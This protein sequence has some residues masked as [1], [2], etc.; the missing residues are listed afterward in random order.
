[1][2]TSAARFPKPSEIK[3]PPGAEGWETL[4]TYGLVFSEDR[5]A[6][7][8]QAFWFQD[9][10]HWREVLY[11]FD[12]TLAEFAITSLSQYNSR[13]FII[14]PAMGIDYRVVNGYFYLTPVPVA[15]GAT[16]A[17]R[18]PHF[19]ERAG[20]Y[21]QNWG[22]LYDQWKVKAREMIAEME[23]ISFEPLPEMVD[24]EWVT[25]GRGVGSGFDMLAAYNRLIELVFKGWQYHFELLNLGYAAYL[26]FFTFCK[27]VF[28]DIPE[29]SIA[30]MVAG[31]NVELFRPDDELKGLARRA[32]ELGVAE[33]LK[34]AGNAA[35]A[36]ELLRE[37]E[38]GRAWLAALEEAKHPW[39]N[40]S[41]GTGFYHHD[42]V[43]LDDLDIPFGHIVDYIGQ[44]ERGVSLERPLD[45][46]C[47]ERDRVAAEYAALLATD[48]DRET[49]DGKLGLA[50]TVFP[51][52][53]NHNFYIEHWMHSVFW[54]KM[55][56]LGQVFADAGFWAA[57]DDVFYLRRDEIPVAIF[58]LGT[59]W[60]VGAPSR[61][62]HVWPREIE[63]RKR[64][65]KA[66]RAWTPPPALGVPPEVVTEPFTVMLW[67]ITSD[68]IRVWLSGASEASLSGFAASP[69]VVEGVARVVKSSK[70]IDDV[71]AGEVIVC[72][73]TAPG[74]APAFSR[75]A[76]A[77]TDIG[78]MMSHAAIV[79]REYGLP[80][81]VGTGFGTQT[82]KTGQRVRVDGSAGTVT[83]LG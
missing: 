74:W 8:E 38:R 49:F 3:T 14:P 64:I 41:A 33:A 16:I 1:M 79:C 27:H 18:V 62:P 11:P 44:L 59:S 35:R 32:V 24:M 10:M 19:I 40:F 69:G 56:R 81:V 39:F 52:I 25:K 68:S 67:G 22:A 43:W 70:E 29:Q 37:S 9:G 55:R 4:Y 77:V 7:E 48:E 46:I 57:A 12:A 82:I 78:G 53:E 73:I 63:R 80:A 58:D 45:S 30:K 66:L 50:R 36:T 6:T 31:I 42:K 72:P 60:A 2:T 65:V 17:E 13:F 21:Y 34:N 47:A 15:D 26:D 23:A 83:I 75:V 76:A 51:Y 28:P 54:R 20:Y 71:L 5:R 61:G